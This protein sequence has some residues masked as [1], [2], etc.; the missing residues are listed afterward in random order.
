MFI[1]GN[2]LFRIEDKSQFSTKS[3]QYLY[4]ETC[5]NHKHYI[6]F[7]TIILKK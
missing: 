4:S 5:V 3:N 6:Y 2:L 7:K 1:N